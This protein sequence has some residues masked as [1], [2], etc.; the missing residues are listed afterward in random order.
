MRDFTLSVN[1]QPESPPRPSRAARGMNHI[2]P[3]W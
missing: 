2:T 3:P 1:A